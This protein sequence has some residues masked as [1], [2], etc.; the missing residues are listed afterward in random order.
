[1]KALIDECCHTSLVQV[2]AE[3]GIP[4]EHVALAGQADYRIWRHA[5]AGGYSI[6]TNNAADFRKLAGQAIAHPGLIILLPNARPSHQRRL[7]QA[8]LRLGVVEEE[9]AGTIVEIDLVGD[10]DV[11]IVWFR[12]DNAT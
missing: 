7:L 10:D 4:A 11:E 6:V 1:M 8:F 5:V 3:F 2:F 12:P 9:M